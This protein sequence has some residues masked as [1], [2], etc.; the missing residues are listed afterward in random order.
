MITFFI[1]LIIFI[2]LAILG[3]YSLFENS[4]NVQE[5]ENENNP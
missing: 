4:D 3:A 2:F 1:I 5:E